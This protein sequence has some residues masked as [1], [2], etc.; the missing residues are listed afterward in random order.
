MRRTSSD[1]RSREP[2][3]ATIRRP[4]FDDQISPFDVTEIPQ[5]FAQG[6][7]IGGVPCRGYCLKNTDA[8]DLRRLLRARRERREEEAT[9]NTA[10]ERSPIHH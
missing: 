4:I 6:V 8:I 7:E 10:D 2:L 5:P 1:A 9:R 3:G